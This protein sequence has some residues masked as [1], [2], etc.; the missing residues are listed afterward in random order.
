MKRLMYLF[1]LPAAAAAAAFMIVVLIQPVFSSPT[2]TQVLSERNEAPAEPEEAEAGEFEDMD[3]F[4]VHPNQEE[5]PEASEEDTGPGLPETLSIPAIDVEADLEEVGILD[6]GQ[7]GVPDSAEGVGWFEPGVRP[8]EQGN[9]VLAGHVDSREGPAVFY[10]LHELEAGDTVYVT[11]EEGSDLEFEVTKTIVYDRREA[12]LEEI[13]G[14]SDGRHLNLIT[15]TGT[16]NQEYGTHD[17]R[18]VVY[19]ELMED[20]AE[21][22]DP[23]ENISVS[24][25]SFRWHAVD[26]ENVVGYRVYRE[27]EDGTVELAASKAAYGRKSYSSEDVGELTH[28]VT[29]VTKDGAESEPS[30]KK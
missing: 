7:M 3:A 30:E 19:T 9:A 27:L 2:E 12:P 24:G 17:D 21:Q 14:R 25:Q 16:F 10:G 13:F 22:P 15:C 29:A 11:D 26:D 1:L 20:E 18:L 23:P 8:G 28:Y 6:N 4:T 5:A